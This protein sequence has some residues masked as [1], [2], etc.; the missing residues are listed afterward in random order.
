[1]LTLLLYLTFYYNIDISVQ[2][3]PATGDQYYSTDT[4]ENFYWDKFVPLATS[5]GVEPIC[6][7]DFL[8]LRKNYRPYFMKSKRIKSKGWHHMAC[9][10][11]DK[12]RERI[13]NSKDEVSANNFRSE[14]LRHTEHTVSVLYMYS[15]AYYKNMYFI[16][17]LPNKYLSINK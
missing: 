14:L 5:I 7:N 1:M 6:K 9:S 11:C 13:G 4:W 12:L 16:R 17:V 2:F 8:Y 10:I 3:D 15:I